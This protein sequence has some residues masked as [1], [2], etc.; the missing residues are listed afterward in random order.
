MY[1]LL[2]WLFPNY[3]RIVKLLVLCGRQVR[4]VYWR[5]GLDKL[6][7]LCYWNLRRRSVGRLHGLFHGLLPIEH[8][9]FELLHLRLGRLFGGEREQLLVV[10]RRHVRA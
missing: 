10:R 2:R 9:D 7:F 4:G 1:K 6:H 5:L 8:G 3:G